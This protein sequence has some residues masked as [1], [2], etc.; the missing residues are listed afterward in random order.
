MSQQ[1]WI[2]PECSAMNIFFPG[3]DTPCMCCETEIDDCD[4]VFMEDEENGL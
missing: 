2:C 3:T 1:I 4:K